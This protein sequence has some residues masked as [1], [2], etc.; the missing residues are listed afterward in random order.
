MISKFI[1]AYI[2][3]FLNFHLIFSQRP[4]TPVDI[5][6]DFNE[7]V[8][9]GWGNATTEEM[10]IQLRVENGELR[11]IIS[12][13][14]P[15]IDS[16]IMFIQSSSRH[17][18]VLRMM[19]FGGAK[20][21]NLLLK[22]G[23]SPTNSKDVDYLKDK[24]TNDVP[25]LKY[26]SC[27]GGTNPE[28]AVDKSLST[29]WYSNTTYG[30]WIVIDSIDYRWV[31]GIQFSTSGLD[32]GAKRV[33]LQQSVTSGNGPFTTVAT[34]NLAKTSGTQTFRG[35]QAHSRYWKLFI[36]DNYGGNSTG[37]VEVNFLSIA[38]SVAT[39]AFD[40]DNTGVYKNYYLPIHNILQGPIVRMRINFFH[41]DVVEYNSNIQ[42]TVTTFREGL[43]FD[44]IRIVRSPEIWK[45]RGCIDKYY[46]NPNQFNPHY[47][48]STKHIYINNKL[49]ISYFEK[50]DSSLQ[51][52]STYDCPHEGN[53]DLFISGIN[54][55]DSPRVFVDNNECAVK[56]TTHAYPG[57]REQNVVC[58]LPKSNNRSVSTC[59][60]RVESSTL[61]GLFHNVAY[62]SYRKATPA[63]DRPVISNIASRKVDIS[64][65]PP[66][67]VFD[68]MMTT[69][70]KI[71]WFQPQFRSRV[72]N[73]TVGNVTK[74]SIRGL[75]PNTA[76]VF[77][78]SA[79]AEGAISNAAILPTDLYGRRDAIEG[80]FE[81]PVSVYTNITYTLDYDINFQFFNSNQSL[82]SSGS[83]PYNSYG[84]T[85]IYGSE[86]NYGLVIVGSAHIEN[87]NA[88][89]TC[90][91]GY[92]ATIG[93]A[94]CGVSA[95]V[96]A[97]LLERR[98]SVKYAVD[99]A[100]RRQVPSNIPYDNGALPEK[101]V[102]TVAELIAGRGA[103]LPSMPCGPALRLTSSFAR[104]SGSM[105]YR[106]KMNVR[107]GF[108][109]TFMFEI[110]NPSLRCS[111]MDDVNT[112]CR[113]RG[114]DG[115][116]F[117]LQDVS[118][119]ALGNAGSGMGYEGIFNSLA[120]EI[121][122]FFNYDQMDYYE[123][124]IAVMTQVRY[125]LMLYLYEV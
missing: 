54:F 51:Y 19:Y 40:I 110:S 114:A 70:Y 36:I 71:V 24:W 58:T 78:V 34:F 95:S 68:T 59:L 43:A 63:P 79:I 46:D 48:V 113:S 28:Y 14:N 93:I 89:T 23:P 42:A 4:E 37:L 108:D 8:S 88:S 13:R 123:N 50:L 5:T 31:V 61:P 94:S 104:E 52:A 102:M 118:P 77:C 69:A 18:L 2:V 27:S 97:V 15:H 33:L 86:G 117:V 105:W 99:G 98:L 39:L 55:G 9:D 49:P 76:Y 81:S 75:E 83:S 56:S 115:L 26:V 21:G 44:Y 111:R 22:Y 57:S 32:S 12:K 66:G 10:G 17:Y 84:P 60:V 107:E 53:V 120:V 91:D 64:W 125:L 103:D 11:G 101:V 1:A 65:S 90:C 30:N 7:G 72:S 47:N 38:E 109:T 119:V 124:H 106:R 100:S 73:I 41:E 62:F 29:E 85:G 16:P 116:A 87:C 122:T 80:Y 20:K 25:H 35:F 3:I 92:N 45:V 6:W 112:Y 74:T 96:C 82:N 67:D 121:D